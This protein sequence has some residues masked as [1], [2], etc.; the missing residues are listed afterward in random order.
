MQVTLE[1]LM[2]TIPV[3]IHLTYDKNLII[4]DNY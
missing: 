1:W 4:F 2:G 3:Q